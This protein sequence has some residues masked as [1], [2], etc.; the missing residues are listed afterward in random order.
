M[1]NI[2]ECPSILCRFSDM[3]VVLNCLK[4]DKNVF[5]KHIEYVS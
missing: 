5:L 1:S 2:A 4:R 3:L